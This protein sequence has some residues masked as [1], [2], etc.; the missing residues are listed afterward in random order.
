MKRATTL[1]LCLVF[2]VLAWTPV[3]AQVEGDY[4][5][6]ASGNWSMA[7]NWQRFNGS[8]W[9]NIGTPPTG[10]ENIYIVGTDSIFVN[11]PV[12]VTGR[13]VVEAAPE[14][15]M[16]NPIGARVVANEMLTIGDGGV[17]QHD[18]DEGT[19][20]QAVWADGSTFHLT[21]TV[22]M[23]PTDR[24]Q[25][26]HHVIFETPGL[27]P[28]LNMQFDDVTIG[29]DIRVLD[30]GIGRWY[31]TSALANESAQVTI[32]GD[33]IV[34]AGNFSVHG[35]GNV[36]TDFVV[37][38]HGDV[39][40]TGGNFSI[41]RGSQPLGTTRWY[42]HGG[43]FRLSGATTQNSNATPGGASFVFI[44]GNTQQLEIGSGATLSNLPISVQGNTTLDAGQSVLA[45]GGAFSL[46][47]GSTLGTG[48]TGGLTQMFALVVGEVTLSPEAGY[49]FSGTEAQVTSARMPTTVASIIIDNP[50]GVALSQETTVT[51]RVV[52][53][54]GV[55][56]NTT[57]FTL[58]A[59]AEVVQEGGSLM[60]PVSNEDE[61]LLPTSFFVDQ[62]YP[63]PFNPST[64]IRFGMA[65]HGHVAVNV[66]N[67]LGQH[68]MTLVDGAMPAGVHELTADFSGLTT[69]VYL[70][71]VQT[72]SST[73]TRQMVLIK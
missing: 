45:G 4:R 2:A 6:R 14:A 44:S 38:H 28:N 63:N 43:D 33:V 8:T 53:R 70:Y 13:L 12:T 15:T 11:V 68:V 71:R 64:T 5:T 54:S 35:T 51:E 26:Y 27:A 39:I 41:T 49:L 61:S 10:A 62:N 3:H 32:M 30:T 17:Y 18:R 7:Q 57:P 9:A 60:H 66:Y 40:V 34:E 20:P 36:G 73:M 48:L 42:L 19:I 24:N 29:G 50:A 1:A 46:E 23:A 59:G 58:D 65:Q 21:G 69:G 72:E 47:A 56:D 16:Q 37:D 55:F 67:T 25:G 22:A 52:L 31:L